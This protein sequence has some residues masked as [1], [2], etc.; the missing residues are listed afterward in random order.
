MNIFAIGVL[1]SW[2][3]AI[4][5]LV[6]IILFLVFLALREFYCWYFKLNTIL[7]NQQKQISLM[8]KQIDILSL[9]ALKN[10][11]PDSKIIAALDKKDDER[12]VAREWVEFQKNK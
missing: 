7:E 1:G 9:L 11:V 5:L 6:P 2:E 8:R 4:V 12:E 10:G 3:I